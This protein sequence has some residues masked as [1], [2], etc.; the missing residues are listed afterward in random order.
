MRFT[1]A[2]ALAVVAA[3]ASLISAT[4]IDASSADKCPIFCWRDPACQGCFL[5]TCV[6]ISSFPRFDNMTHLYGRPFLSAIRLIPR[7]ESRFCEVSRASAFT[8]AQY[9]RWH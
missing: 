8:S 1:F 7:S 2:I 5:K 3:L 4:P 9:G 6:S